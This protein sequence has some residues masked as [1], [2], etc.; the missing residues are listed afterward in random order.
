M[1][2]CRDIAEHGSHFV[3]RNIPWYKLPG[4][5]LHLFICGNCRRFIRHLRAT[6]K[7]AAGLPRQSAAPET[8]SSVMGALPVAPTPD[9]KAFPAHD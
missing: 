9:A 4:W 5:Y 1:L 6:I 8:V 3:D 7:V 2:K